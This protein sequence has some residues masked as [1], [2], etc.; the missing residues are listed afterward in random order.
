MVCFDHFGHLQAFIQLSLF[1][2]GC[3]ISQILHGV[4][5]LQKGWLIQC[6]GRYSCWDGGFDVVI[7]MCGCSKLRQGDKFTSSIYTA[8]TTEKSH[9]AGPPRL[10]VTCFYIQ[11]WGYQGSDWS[12]KVLKFDFSF[13]RTWKVWNWTLDIVAEKVMRKSWF[14]LVLSWKTKILNP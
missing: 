9:E 12:W 6:R 7:G 11:K 4:E 5:I 10:W 14:L 2:Y 1:S 3:R 13:Y 8:R